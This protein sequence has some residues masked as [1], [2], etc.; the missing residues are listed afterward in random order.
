[1][2]VYDLIWMKC[3]SLLLKLTTTTTTKQT[4]KK[5]TSGWVLLPDGGEARPEVSVASAGNA[6]RGYGSE[7]TAASS[8]Y[9]HYAWYSTNR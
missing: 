2:P 9:A 3:C 1:M 7:K 6:I 5:N 4:K 8:L